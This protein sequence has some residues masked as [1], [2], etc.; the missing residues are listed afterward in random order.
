MIVVV[1]LGCC[2]A[3]GTG[4][5]SPLIGQAGMDVAIFLRGSPAGPVT[6]WGT[7]PFF[8]GRSRI[9]IL[10]PGRRGIIAKVDAFSIEDVSE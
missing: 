7:R 3:A 5:C 9:A 10:Y 1:G 2:Q 8:E 6:L 4:F